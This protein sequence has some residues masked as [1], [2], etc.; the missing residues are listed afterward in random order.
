[1]TILLNG[2]AAPH[3]A[4]VAAALER[5]GISAEAKGIAVAVNGS[6]VRRAEWATQPLSPGDRVEVIRAVAGG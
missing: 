6:V 4:T 5:L 2:E 1:M 3:V